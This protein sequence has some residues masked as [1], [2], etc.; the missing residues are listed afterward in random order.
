MTPLG[1]NAPVPEGRPMMRQT[2]RAMLMAILLLSGGLPS[3]AHASDP[4]QSDRWLDRWRR[5]GEQ[6]LLWPAGYA[7]TRP[8]VTGPETASANIVRPT[9]TIYR[10]TGANSGAA[11]MVFPGGGYQGLA[12]GLEGT[13]V[14]DWQRGSA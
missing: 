9:M 12:V 2:G 11:L 10:P 5:G 3:A 13:E 1:Q 7:I 8:E 4:P 6:V 14:C